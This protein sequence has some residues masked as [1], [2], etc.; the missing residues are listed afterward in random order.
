MDASEVKPTAEEPADLTVESP[1]K[2][3]VKA[4]GREE[5]LTAQQ[6]AIATEVDTFPTH[7]QVPLA[8]TRRKTQ[9]QASHP[10]E[11]SESDEG[12]LYAQPKQRAPIIP[13]PK[14]PTRPTWRDRYR[15]CIED[16]LEPLEVP[17]ADTSQKIRHSLDE[18][19]KVRG[20]PRSILKKLH[21]IAYDS[22]VKKTS[23]VFEDGTDATVRESG[24]EGSDDDE[25]A[26]DILECIRQ[27]IL[28]EA[29]VQKTPS[30]ERGTEDVDIDPVQG[31]VPAAGHKRGRQREKQGNVLLQYRNDMAC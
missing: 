29:K 4:L 8:N 19:Q 16:R 7:P 9:L 31:P 30:T 2:I 20:D 18:A 26:P 27:I 15:R 6:T 11:G 5:G 10:P 14:P 28:L 24:V 13:Q 12:S 21:K 23:E 3:Q 22:W 1:L 17:I 25:C